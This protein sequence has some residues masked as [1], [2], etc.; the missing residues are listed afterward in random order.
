MGMAKNPFTVVRT[1][2]E[3]QSPMQY[4][5]PKGWAGAFAKNRQ[6]ESS[7]WNDPQAAQ[8]Q[9]IREQWDYA[10][11]VYHPLENAAIAEVTGGVEDEANRAGDIATNAFGRAR[12]QRGRDMARYGVSQTDRQRKS[13]TRRAAIAETT[14]VAD[15]ENSTRRSVEDRNMNAQAK[16][17]GH[18]A[19]VA[20]SANENLASASNLASAREQTGEAMKAKAKQGQIGGAMS[21]AAAG[22]MMTGGNP[23]GAAAGAAVG[24]F[25]G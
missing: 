18:G 7:A 21:G 11:E 9:L 20:S 10:K 17:I 6:G 5:L 22:F 16:L 8:A 24:F 14:G 4:N 25:L 23:L 2:D 19:G 12:E 3:S 15:A 13:N 1:S